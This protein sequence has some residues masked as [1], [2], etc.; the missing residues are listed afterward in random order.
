MNKIET[1]TPIVS[2]IDGFQAVVEKCEAK[3]CQER[4]FLPSSW[5]VFNRGVRMF[6][7]QFYPLFRERNRLDHT[8]LFPIKQE[9]IERANE[10]G[11]MAILDLMGFGGIFRD[12]EENGYPF[13]HGVSV[14]LAH[15]DDTEARRHTPTRIPCDYVTGNILFDETWMELKKTMCKRN[16][17]KFGLILWAPAGGFASRYM[18]ESVAV[19]NELLRRTWELLSVRNGLLL[20]EIPFFLRYNHES[21]LLNWTQRVGSTL[22]APIRNRSFAEFRLEEDTYSG[23]ML[24][25]KTPFTRVLPEL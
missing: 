19:Y 20:A 21:R 17:T 15:D 3:A 12:M 14:S 4:E 25:E 11:P 18:T 22:H 13:S 16:I 23:D 5:S 10:D 2:N 9:L 8:S 1:G 7:H 6:E 24:L